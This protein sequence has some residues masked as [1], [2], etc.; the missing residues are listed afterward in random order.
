M[1]VIV[2]FDLPTDTNREKR[3]YRNFRKYLLKSGFIMMQE[4]VY[5][6]LVQND[7]AASTVV[8]GIRGHKPS[9]GIVQC[10]RV[11]E[12]QYSRM[13]F[14]VGERHT[15]VLDSTDKLIVL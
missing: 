3:E 8:G 1:R 13:E 4:S 12:K 14:I 11:T 9:K 6:K 10:I 15:D 5:C 7:V 2:F